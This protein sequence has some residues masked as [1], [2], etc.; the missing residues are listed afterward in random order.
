MISNI[1]M[2]LLIVATMFMLTSVAGATCT[3]SSLTGTYGFVQT[4]TNSSGK[5]E[6]VVGQFT[7]TP[8]APMGTLAGTDTFDV[9]GVVSTF[10]FTGT[11]QVFA[12]CTGK[13]AVTDVGGKSSTH[14]RFVVVTDGKELDLVGANAGEVTA[15]YALAQGSATCTN[16][17]VKGNFGFVN[18]GA[19]VGVGAIAF[20][21]R[22]TFDGAVGI[23]GTES[24]S[25]A[26]TI[27]TGVPL[28][29]TYAI[30]SDCTG[31]GILTPSGGTATNFNLVVVNSGKTILA[32][33]TDANTVVSGSL[34]H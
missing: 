34:Q 27:V 10:S 32:V 7:A 23:T 26:G 1:R 20:D 24:G 19:I 17:G 3:N 25:E 8:G 2:S 28:T 6:V 22:L 31:T 16:A 21:G 4:G 5:P 11:Y 9:D 13:A 12:N 15:G 18:A 30:N 14:Y 29:G 33:E